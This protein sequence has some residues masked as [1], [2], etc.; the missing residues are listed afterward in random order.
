MRSPKYTTHKKRP[1]PGAPGGREADAAVADPDGPRDRPRR[2]APRPPAAAGTRGPFDF[3]LGTS[4][5]WSS[6]VCTLHGRTPYR[7][8]L[9]LLDGILWHFCVFHFQHSGIRLFQFL[10]KTDHIKRRLY[11]NTR[12]DRDGTS[13]T[14]DT[15]NDHTSGRPTPTAR[16]TPHSFYLVRTQRT[17]ARSVLRPPPACSM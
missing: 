16:P 11:T 2:A 4:P 10:Y 12:H 6:K 3:V 9:R 14:R 13:C 15:T 7:S 1:G 5:S 17:R 8:E